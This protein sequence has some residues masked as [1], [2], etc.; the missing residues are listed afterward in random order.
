MVKSR[1]DD[2][3]LEELAGLA[4][5]AAAQALARTIV[6]SFEALEATRPLTELQ[7]AGIVESALLAFDG[8]RADVLEQLRVDATIQSWAARRRARV[9]GDREGDLQGD[10]LDDA[11]RAGD[12]ETAVRFSGGRR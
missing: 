7:K 10:G 4:Q 9:D 2:G 11:V 6:S 8:Y 3:R 12:R 5:V 1:S